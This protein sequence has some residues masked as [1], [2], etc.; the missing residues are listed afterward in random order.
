M[1]RVKIILDVDTATGIPCRD[2]DDGLAI[3]L[4]LASP[5]I[6]LL[7]I[8]TCAGNCRTHEST[9]NSLRILELAGREDIPVA[10]GRELP[11]LQDVTANFDFLD[12]W[13]RDYAFLCADVPPLLKVTAKKSKSPAHEFIIKTVRENPGEV[14]IVNEGSHTNLALALL[15]DPEITPLIKEVIHMGGDTGQPWWTKSITSEIDDPDIWQYIIKMNQ[16]YDPEATAIVAT[17]G[18]PFTFVTSQSCMSSLLRMEHVDAIKGVGTPYHDFLADTARP[19]VQW[20][21]SYRGREGAVMWDPLTLAMCID[22]TL[23]NCVS[24]RFDTER[25]LGGDHPY[26]YPNVDTPQVQVTMTAD[27][28]RY[29]KLMIERLTRPLS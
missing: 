28:D 8:T 13:T 23:F 25:F 18:I 5:E 4:A 7:G 12:G 17:S 26:L 14:T 1:E 3:A 16:T 29:E 6:E 11:F 15:V 21:L 9:E 19:W 10:E 2:V 27:G 24:M 20:Q 22:R